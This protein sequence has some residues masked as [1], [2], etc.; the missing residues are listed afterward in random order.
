V[1]LALGHDIDYPSSDLLETLITCEQTL[2]AGVFKKL[3]NSSGQSSAIGVVLK[4]FR[5]TPLD[6]NE[7]FQHPG[8]TVDDESSGLIQR[9]RAI[10][11]GPAGFLKAR[12][13]FYEARQVAGLFFQR[14]NL[15]FILQDP[16]LCLL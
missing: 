11:D 10:L 4:Q 13:F 9:F 15:S 5:T 3:E 8:D 6:C 7:I 1:P 12:G 2:F 16:Q 14:L